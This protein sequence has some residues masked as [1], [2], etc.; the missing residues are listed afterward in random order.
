[1]SDRTTTRTRVLAAVTLII[2]A[3]GFA[4]ATGA[5]ARSREDGSDIARLGKVAPE[6][7]ITLEDGTGAKLSSLVQD[8]RTIVVFHSP[9]C[10]VCAATLPALQPFPSSLRLV[11]VDVS[12]NPMAPMRV[13]PNGP[14]HVAANKQ[15]V[16]RLFPFSGLPTIVFLDETGVIRAGLAGSQP[17]GRIQEALQAF[18]GGK[19]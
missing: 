1:M 10:G 19:R 3:G 11:M 6:L 8:R 7:G 2:C 13:E 16:Q 9:V 5:P 4:A 12:G 15:V 18:A 17:T 14:R